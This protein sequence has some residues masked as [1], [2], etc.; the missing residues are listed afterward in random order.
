MNI[1]VNKKIKMIVFVLL[2]IAV[3]LGVPGWI[4]LY[5]IK[6]NSGKSIAVITKI[7]TV[8]YQKY[9]DYEFK[10]NNNIY[11]GSGSYRSILKNTGDTVAVIFNVKNP[12]INKTIEDYNDFS[13][14]KIILFIVVLISLFYWKLSSLV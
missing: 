2:L 6:M 8:R 3:I 5:S 1:E 14:L 10:I 7:Y 4:K 12:K 11:Y 13:F 9:I